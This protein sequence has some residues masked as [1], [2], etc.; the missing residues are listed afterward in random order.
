MR[1]ESWVGITRG[2][3]TTFSLVLS[4]LFLVELMLE[5]WAEGPR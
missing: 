2:A 5:L 1:E 3:L 4:C